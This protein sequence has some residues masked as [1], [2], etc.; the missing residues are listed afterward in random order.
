MRCEGGQRA[1]VEQNRR[2]G[3]RQ[4]SSRGGCSI[5][6]QNSGRAQGR[7][8]DVSRVSTEHAAKLDAEDGNQLTESID[9]NS[10]LAQIQ[11]TAGGEYQASLLVFTRGEEPDLPT[12]LEEY[13]TAEEGGYTLEEIRRRLGGDA[14]YNKGPDGRMHLVS[15]EQSRDADPQMTRVVVRFRFVPRDQEAYREMIRDFV[16][17]HGRS[18]NQE[19]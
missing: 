10:E 14:G 4:A 9:R 17:R 5:G 18:P 2:D 16:G 7:V 12:P 11:A 8:S 1:S 6:E 15:L 19:D 13:V 3:P